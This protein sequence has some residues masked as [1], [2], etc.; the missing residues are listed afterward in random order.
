M[1]VMHGPCTLSCTPETRHETRQHPGRSSYWWRPYACRY[2]ARIGDM[3][4][5]LQLASWAVAPCI[6]R[7]QDP[8]AVG[9]GAAVALRA[10]KTPLL[11]I[12]VVTDGSCALAGLPSQIAGLAA[13]AIILSVYSWKRQIAA[14]VIPRYNSSSLQDF[15]ASLVVE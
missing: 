13:V 6:P 15:A 2:G 8:L 3:R 7:P 12:R 11:I 10:R 14:S 1:Y 5:H 4:R 9:S